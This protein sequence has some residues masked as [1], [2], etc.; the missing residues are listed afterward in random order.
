MVAVRKAV[1]VSAIA[2]VV[3]LVLVAAVV[4]VRLVPGQTATTTTTST[5]AC[6]SQA[7][8]ALCTSTEGT[9]SGGSPAYFPHSRPVVIT[10]NVTDYTLPNLPVNSSYS[11]LAGFQ[12]RVNNTEGP[13]VYDSSEPKSCVGRPLEVV[14]QPGQ[15]YI[16]TYSWNQ[17]NNDGSQVPDGVYEIMGKLNGSGYVGSLNDP[18]GMVYLGTPLA[19]SQQQFASHFIVVTDPEE[20]YPSGTPVRIVEGL[21]NNGGTIASIQTTP[22]SISYEIANQ[23]GY[24]IYDS[25]LHQSC[26][27]PAV[28]SPMAPE[29]YLTRTVYWNQTDN[30]G[31]QVVA[32]SYFI[33]V[34]IH[35]LS[36]GL[37]LEATKSS[38]LAIV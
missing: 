24:D 29:E 3:V 10:F 31:K 35:V 17:T 33:I 18:L 28:D 1:L 36:N 4:Y 5:E 12:V 26:V 11:C 2:V 30:Q 14:L 9:L 13:V 37:L 7:P 15:S 34:N 20:S 19:V 22:C 25:M 6:I 8:N 23:T 32:G 27:G 38:H 16:E 21:L